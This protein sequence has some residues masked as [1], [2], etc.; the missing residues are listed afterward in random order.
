MPGLVAVS[1]H[2]RDPE[3]RRTTMNF[4]RITRSAPAAVSHGC[5]RWAALLA[6]VLAGLPSAAVGQ[7]LGEWNP[8][9]GGSDWTHPDDPQPQGPLNNH[10]QF[11]I[12][13]VAVHAAHLPTGQILVWAYYG[14]SAR[15]WNVDKGKFTNVGIDRWLWCGGQA[16]LA[17]GSILVAGGGDFDPGQHHGETQTTIF[18]LSGTPNG[19]WDLV[20]DMNFARWYPTCTTL[21]DG[22]ILTVAGTNWDGQSNVQVTIPEIFDPGQVVG[23]Q[24]LPSAEKPL[25]NYPFMF[26]LPDGR[27]FFAGPGTQTAVLDLAP[28]ASW[29]DV[30]NS[31]PLIGGRG[32]A[33]MYEP[34]KV[35]KAGGTSGSPFDEN[36]TAWIDLNVPSSTNGDWEVLFSAPMQNAR[37][38][39][40]LVLLPDGKILAV[41]GEQFDE[42]TQTWS[43]VFAAEWF[44]PNDVPPM[45]DELAPMTVPREYH[46]TAVLLADGKVLATGGDNFPSAEIFS[47]PYLFT[48]QPRP[49][50]GY[51]PTVVQYGSDFTVV[52]NWVGPQG[53]ANID[54]VNLVRLA[55]VTHWF[56]MNQRFVPLE[57]GHA[58]NESVNVTAPADANLAPPGYYMLFLISDAG[59]PSVAKYVRIE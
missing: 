27:I 4:T 24:T 37:Q 56:D 5:A 40:N 20:G 45:W 51:A 54:Q 21:P 29:T 2:L 46:S 32:A 43:T 22:K 38:H 58:T 57:F 13:G 30:G 35:L 25:P 1:E 26:V 53:P 10:P 39:H 34:G 55:A 41:G 28:P 23:W 3:V 12:G 11:L 31:S 15:L 6:L 7:S 14:S 18:R 49:S 50:I 17:D 42:I 47:P 48:G 52:F 16:A 59:V 19:P 33:V 8:P 44:D 9:P 36:L